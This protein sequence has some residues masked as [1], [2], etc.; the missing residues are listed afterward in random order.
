MLKQKGQMLLSLLGKL[1]VSGHDF[2]EGL[3]LGLVDD[4]SVQG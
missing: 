4:Q 1:R 2:K 3:D